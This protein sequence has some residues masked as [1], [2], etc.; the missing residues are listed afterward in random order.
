MYK[1]SSGARARLAIGPALLA[2]T[3]LAGLPAHAQQGLEVVVVTAEKRSEDLQKVPMQVQ[4]LTA[5]KL[6]DLHLTDFTDFARYMPNVTYAVS[7]QG[8]NGGPGYA[9]ITMRGIVSDQNGN[10]SG[11]EPT[12]GVYFDEM[13]I[14]TINGTL[15]IPTYDVQRVEA[16]SGPQGTLYGASAESGVIRIVSNKPDTSGFEASY[17]ANVNTV[18]HGGFGYDLDAM[19]NIPVSDNIAL[20]I[21]GWDEHDAGYIDNVPGTRTYTYNNSNPPIVP[22]PAPITISNAGHTRNNYNTVDKMGARA[23]LSIDLDNNWTITPTLMGESEISDGIFGYDPSVGDLKVQH[24]LPEYDHD[25]WYQAGLTVQGKIG[26]LDLTYAG[27]YMDRTVHSAADYT[28]YTYWYDQYNSYYTYF[29]DNAGNEI[30]P[31]QRILGFDHFTKDSQELRVSSSK[32]N[33]FRFTAGLFYEKQT[34]FILQDYVIEN[35]ASP[36]S[37]QPVVSVDGWPNTLWLTDQMRSDQDYAAFGEASFDILPNLTV[38]GGIRF[39]DY[40][41]S[42]KGFF[43]FQSYEA[44][45][46]FAPTSV[47]GGPCTDLNSKVSGNGETHK[48]NL[49]WQ[50]TDDQMVYATYSTGFRPGGVNRVID[51]NT[52]KPFLPYTPDTL[53]NYEIGWKTS[54]DDNRVR[55]NGAFYWEDWNNF[56]FPFLGPNSVTIVENAGNARV[57]GFEF[58][59]TWLPIDNLTLSAAGAYNDGSLTSPYCGTTNSAGKPITSCPGTAEAPTGT[60]L[61]ITPLWKVN[62]TARYEWMIG[63]FRAHVQGSAVHQSGTWSDLRIADRTL[64]GKNQAFTTF[65][66]TTGIERDNWSLELNVQNLFDERGQLGRYAECTPGTC[67]FEPYILVAQPRTIGLT[68]SQKF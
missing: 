28:D 2:S 50:V 63:N 62:A 45:R 22:L 67:G 52:N 7:G 59:G 29:T 37:G 11:P 8:S 44:S 20:R 65:D 30:D 15:D 16:L 55:F 57:K 21:V 53:D 46:C 47:D 61:P 68:L 48:V 60:Q 3:M 5:Q 41:N 36:G 10:H 4:A 18:D 42:L 43:G 51:P 6:E 19:V 9:N 1:I 56:Q 14:T 64:L 58:E 13:P 23:A 17:A 66:F 38:T 25:K 35:L 34:H 32:E 24:F 54:W 39:Y 49:T 31:T 12:V 27:G 26:D 33:R 40:D